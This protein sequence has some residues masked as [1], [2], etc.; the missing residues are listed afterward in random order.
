MTNIKNKI[1]FFASVTVFILCVFSLEA[2]AHFMWLN[3]KPYTI[4][5]G[6]PVSLTISNDHVFGG[7]GGEFLPKDSLDRL[8][9]IQP[10]GKELKII[11]KNEVEYQTEVPL[12]DDGTYVF[13]TRAKGGFFSKTA[14]GYKIGQTKKDLKNVISCTYSEKQAKAIVTIGKGGGNVFSKTLGHK[15]EI[16]PLE[17]PSNL[18]EGDFV[19]L[20]VIFE[21]N[22]LKTYVFATFAGFSTDDSTFAYATKS[23][24]NG[25]AKVKIIKPGLWL[26]IVKHEV[27]YPDPAKCDNFSLSS[28]L[29]F[30]VK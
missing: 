19:R 23:D 3:M 10:D 5:G 11:P 20:K 12:K 29:T 2:S 14:E 13:V 7:P 16:V 8:Y 6:V 22:P 9:G 24:E 17:N 18:K 15:L 27:P 26:V 1:V 4:E 25:I 30:E 21:G 28:S